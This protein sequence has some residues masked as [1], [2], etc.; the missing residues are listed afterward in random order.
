MKFFADTG[1]LIGLAKIHSLTLLSRIASQ[2]LIPPV[3]QKELFGKLGE[4]SEE[5]DKALTD[6]LHLATPNAP[7]PTI[8]NIIERLDEGEKQVLLLAYPERENAIVLM[9]DKLGRYAAQ[10]LGIKITGLVGLLLRFKEKGLIDEIAPLLETSRNKG[11]WLSDEVV[12]IALRLAG[13]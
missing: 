5:I 6:F 7:D 12:T 13:E 1:P 10:Q 8:E 9:D 4:E 3:V 11:Y 2:V